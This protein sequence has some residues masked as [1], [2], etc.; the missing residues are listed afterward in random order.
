MVSHWTM[1]WNLAMPPDMAT[2]IGAMITKAWS[3]HI[4]DTQRC[5]EVKAELESV[6]GDFWSVVCCTAGT[7]GWAIVSNSDWV[8][9]HRVTFERGKFEVHVGKVLKYCDCKACE[10]CKAK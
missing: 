5:F 6:Y 2:R 3:H 7:A 9:G 10:A 4:T 8:D 1:T